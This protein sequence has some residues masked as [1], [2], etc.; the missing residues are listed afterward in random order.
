MVAGDGEGAAAG[1][2]EGFGEAWGGGEE[3]AF[4]AEVE[5]VAGEEDVVDGFAAEEVV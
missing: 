5:G 4:E 1:E 3:F 2:G